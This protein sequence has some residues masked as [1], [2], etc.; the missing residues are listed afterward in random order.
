MKLYIRF[1]QIVVA[2]SIHKNIINFLFLNYGQRSYLFMLLFF[3]FTSE[4]LIVKLLKV[5][6]V[7]QGRD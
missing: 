1:T 6:I 3:V 2:F 5:K 4:I 7:F